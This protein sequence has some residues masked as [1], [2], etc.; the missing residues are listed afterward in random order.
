MIRSRSA[1]LAA[2]LFL[3]LVKS[4]ACI[5]PPKAREGLLTITWYIE[6]ASKMPRVDNLVEKHPTNILSSPT[7]ETIR[8]KLRAELSFHYTQTSPNFCPMK[9][10]HGSIGIA[11]FAI[12]KPRSKASTTQLHE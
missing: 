6:V 11:S 9:Y 10:K 7:Q 4:L 8:V 1:G 12:F 5:C 3:H 2:S